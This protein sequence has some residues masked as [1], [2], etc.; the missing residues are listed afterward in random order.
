MLSEDQL[1]LIYTKLYNA[2]PKWFNIGLNLGIPYSTLDA[3]KMQSSKSETDV[4]E[5]CLREMLYHRLHFGNKDSLTWE[6]LCACLQAPTVGRN[7]VAKEINDWIEGLCLLFIMLL[8][9]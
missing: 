7:D 8:L 6:D 1:G 2:R 5:A 9:S 3:I 4:C